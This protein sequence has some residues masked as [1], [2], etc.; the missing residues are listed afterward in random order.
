MSREPRSL[1]ICSAL[2]ADQ[3]SHAWS[4]ARV[5]SH[6]DRRSSGPLA[7][8]VATMTNLLCAT[9]AD[10]CKQNSHRAA[11]D[12]CEWGPGRLVVSREGQ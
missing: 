8:A 5:D 11:F 12:V 10:L 3:S 4:Y 9:V 7:I 1:R 6:D 2:K